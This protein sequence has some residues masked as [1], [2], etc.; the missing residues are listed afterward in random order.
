FDVIRGSRR[1]VSV[2]APKVSRF[3]EGGFDVE[4][5]DFIE[6]AFD[7]AFD[8][9]LGGAGTKEVRLELIA[10][11]VFVLI[12]AGTNDAVAGTVGD[13]IDAA[14]M[15]DGLLYRGIDCWSDANIAKEG[16]AAVR[17]RV[18]GRS[19]GS[20]CILMI[21]TNGGDE[22][23]V[24]KSGFGDGSADMASPILSL[25]AKGDNF[26][27]LAGKLAALAKAVTCG[28]SLAFRTGYQATT[29]AGK[30]PEAVALQ[31]M[32]PSE[33]DFYSAWKNG[34]FR[35]QPVDFGGFTNAE[36]RTKKLMKEYRDR[37]AA[38]AIL[39][40]VPGITAGQAVGWTM[41]GSP[42]IPCVRAI[43]RVERQKVAMNGGERHLTADEYGELQTLKQTLAVSGT[44]VSTAKAKINK[45]AQEIIHHGPGIDSPGLEQL[46]HDINTLTR[47]IT[48]HSDTIRARLRALH[49]KRTGSK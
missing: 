39:Y 5:V 33:R 12:F 7:E 46:Q 18:K 1:G 19:N 15:G 36:P 11:V 29:M 35:P 40:G 25:P 42:F 30:D 22:V 43:M 23:T 4:G 13:D 3:D 31:G 6:H 45:M 10:D 24:G 21:P 26:E 14:P 37:A 27:T 32:T 20:H 47:S 34:T 9:V 38:L 48:K 16:E 2:V 49:K 28:E 44:T 41:T 8:G 17:E